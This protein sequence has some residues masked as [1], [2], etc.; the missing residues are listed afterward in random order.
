MTINFTATQA[1]RAL[2]EKIACRAMQMR[3]ISGTYADK[4]DVELDLLAVHANGCPLKLTD[5]LNADDFQFAHDVFGIAR[6]LN[7]KTGRLENC[8]LPR[9]AK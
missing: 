7:R 5:M 9:Y 2:I 3:G 8:F 1:D 6:H 4:I